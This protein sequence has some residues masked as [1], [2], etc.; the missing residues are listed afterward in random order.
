[1]SNRGIQIIGNDI[2][3]S[4]EKVASIAETAILGYQEEFKEQILFDNKA[5][6]ENDRI[7]E[8][9]DEVDSLNDAL[10]D[11]EAELDG[12]KYDV[13]EA[14]EKIEELEDKIVELEEQLREKNNGNS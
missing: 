3:H 9:Q 10:T 13:E 6:Q 4:R 14:N 1:M 7:E 5:E 2:Y 8:L 12:L 11:K